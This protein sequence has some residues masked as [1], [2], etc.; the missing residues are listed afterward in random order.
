MADI[1]SRRTALKVK[2]AEE[3]DELSPGTV[4]IAPTSTCW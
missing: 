4:Y 3:A 1:L 2:Q